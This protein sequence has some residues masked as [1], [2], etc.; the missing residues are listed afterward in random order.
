[1]Y[2]LVASQAYFSDD[3]L[4][5][6]RSVDQHVLLYSAYLTDIQPDFA[7]EIHTFVEFSF[8]SIYIAA[9]CVGV[10]TKYKNAKHKC[11]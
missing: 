7:R 8:V 6:A 1:M 11:A 9:W 5:L 4:P 2:S 10:Y 3:Y